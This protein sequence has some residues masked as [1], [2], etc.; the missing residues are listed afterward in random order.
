MMSGQPSWASTV[1]W[2]IEGK[3]AA[4]S[5]FVLSD[6]DDL[7]DEG[8]CAIVSLTERMPP[9]LSGETRFAT[10]HLPIEDMTPPDHEQIE[11]FVEFVDRHVTNGCAVGVHCLAGLGRTGTMIACYLVSR[12]RSAEDAI[13]EVRQARPG[14]IQT[15]LQEQAV[16]R[17]AMIQ[18][19]ESGIADFL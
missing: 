5:A 11:T 6:L 3:V 2:I 4:F 1:S 13:D 9:E 19:G 12:G 16:R 10:L 15:E 17:W 8:I 18:S 7:E 14:S